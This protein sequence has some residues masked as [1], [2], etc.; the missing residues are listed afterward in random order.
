MVT[1]RRSWEAAA[2]SPA[3][4][5]RL[6][7][8]RRRSLAGFLFV[9]PGIVPLLIFVVYP[10]LSA[11]YLSFTNWAL[12][13]APQLQGLSTYTNLFS[14]Q[15]FRTSLI[16]TLEIAIGTAVPSCLL[17]LGVA[18][19]LNA[20]ARFTAWYQPLFFLPAVL[21]T[22]VTTIVWGI[23]YQGNG[24]VNSLFGLNVAWLTD[25]RW[26]LP[27]L[28]IM[29]LWTN[30][31]YYAVILLAGL[32]DVPADYYEAARIDGAGPLALLWHITLPL[33][34]PALLFVLVTA[35]SGALTLFVQ[36]YLLTAGGPG[37]AT[38]TLSELIYDTAF[39]YLNVG[40]ASAMSFI[41]LVLSLLIAFVQF[42]LLSPKDT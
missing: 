38:R 3:R 1:H 14:D 35:T 41:L 30:L 28:V 26:A 13:G 16:V 6:T 24:V 40:K 32:R 37:D 20:R 10:M 2:T 31:G 18:L 34:R 25:A 39:S 5:R 11:L 33:I 21:P 7:L 4:H 15:Q 42:R 22:V 17:A 12:M 19:L 27:A 29:I 36:P 23:L 8:A 9:V